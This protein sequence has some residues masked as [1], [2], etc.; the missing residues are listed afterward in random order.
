VTRI[1]ISLASGVLVL[2]AGA[3]CFRALRFRFAELL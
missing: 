1:A 2:T 3:V